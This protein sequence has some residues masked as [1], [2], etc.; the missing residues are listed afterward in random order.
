MSEPI[1][2]TTKGK[3]GTERYNT[4][5][6]FRTNLIIL[7]VYNGFTGIELAETLKIA[8]KRILDFE[9]GRCNP[10]IYELDIISKYFEV[11]IDQLMHQRVKITF[12]Q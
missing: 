11:T 12:E 5:K 4:F 2:I 10:T 3:V 7:R 6:R 1:Y 8:K 9:T